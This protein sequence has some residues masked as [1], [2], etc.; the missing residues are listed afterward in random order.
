MAA[1]MMT[2]MTTVTTKP[3]SASVAAADDDATTATDVRTYLPAYMLTCVPAYCLRDIVYPL[4][5]V[6]Y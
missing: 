2:T 4:L 5:L 1:A 3:A 6:N